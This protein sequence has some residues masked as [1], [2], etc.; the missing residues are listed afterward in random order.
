MG[1]YHSIDLLDNDYGSCYNYIVTLIVGAWPAWERAVVHNAVRSQF[2]PS[3]SMENVILC[4][5]HGKGL[6]C[7]CHMEQAICSTIRGV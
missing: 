3:G 1:W 7:P 6:H 2:F 4:C 5:V